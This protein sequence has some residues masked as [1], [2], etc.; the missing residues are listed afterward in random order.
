M[1]L[2]VRARRR[3]AADLGVRLPMLKSI[4]LPLVGLALVAAGASL[5]WHRLYGSVNDFSVLGWRDP[6]A[7]ATVAAA[8]SAVV[9]AMWILAEPRSTFVGPRFLATAFGLLTFA[10]TLVSVVYLPFKARF[11]TGV[12]SGLAWT[13]FSTLG[14]YLRGAAFPAP[15]PGLYLAVIGAFL[16]V[17]GAMRLKPRRG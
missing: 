10:G 4:R 7:V 3:R 5:S 16:I 11:V 6:L 12:G 9:A 13:G 8:L 1:L 2:A 15:G 14:T 17:I